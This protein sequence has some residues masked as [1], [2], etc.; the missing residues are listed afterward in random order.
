[1]TKRRVVRA[2]RGP[3]AELVS[4]ELSEEAFAS[5]EPDEVAVRVEVA[6]LEPL[7][8]NGETRSDAPEAILAGVIT[9]AGSAVP[10]GV[11]A[12][13]TVIGIGPPADHVTLPESQVWCLSAEERILITGQPVIRELS[14]QVLSA[15]R[16][17]ASPR[18]VGSLSGHE[19]TGEPDELFDVLIHGVADPAD[20]QESLAL[21]RQDGRAFLLVPPGRHVLPLDFYPNVH[22]SC[23]R[24]FVRRV[25]SR[26][27][28]QETIEVDPLLRISSPSQLAGLPLEEIT[29][30]KLLAVAWP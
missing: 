26:L 19:P 16:P 4:L 22:R 17:G 18:V 15:L 30:S 11:A 7:A 1:M 2:Q 24:L 27:L 23:L 14:A 29:G 12:G 5:P 28:E 20:L 6:V 3:E 25:G 21:L 8:L 10:K 9:E 13:Q